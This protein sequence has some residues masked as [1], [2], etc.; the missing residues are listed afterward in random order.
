MKSLAPA[1]IVVMLALVLTGA[2]ASAKLAQM[3]FQND[4]PVVSTG[5][6]DLS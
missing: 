5:T 1:M 3:A 4:A 2:S 6:T